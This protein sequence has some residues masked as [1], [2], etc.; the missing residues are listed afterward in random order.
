MIDML[1]RVMRRIVNEEVK[2]KA[3]SHTP[4]VNAEA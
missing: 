4:V 3:V 2:L 1:L